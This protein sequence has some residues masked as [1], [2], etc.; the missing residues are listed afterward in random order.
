[1]KYVEAFW[2]EHWDEQ[3]VHNR[4][5]LASAVAMIINK[6]NKVPVGFG[7]MFIMRNTNNNEEETLGFLSDVAVTILHQGKGLGR[8]IINYLAGA[9]AVQD[10]SQRQASGSLCLM[11]A[12]RG[13]GAISG[14]KLYKR[15]GFEHL[16]TVGNQ[17]AIF[18]LEK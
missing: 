16:D 7:R 1:M 3:E 13:S 9:Y 8:V 2:A 11:R 15:L 12:D 17:I 10:A 5:L 14:L 4:I 6:I 18:S